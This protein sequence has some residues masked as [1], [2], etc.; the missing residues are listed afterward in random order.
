MKS[1]VLSQL[2]GND[3]VFVDGDWV[4]S[5][6]QDPDGSIRLIQLAD[7]GDGI[8]VNKSNRYLTAD[9]AKELRCTFLKTDDVL[10][11]RMPDPL[12]RACIFP[13]LETQ[14]V[15]VVDVC[16]VRPDKN[17]AFSEWVMYLINSPLFRN[18]IA[19][20]VTGT[21]RQRIS[22]GNLEKIEFEL[23]SIEQQKQI[24]NILKQS[25]EIRQKRKQVIDLLDEYL[26]SVFL[27]MFGDP[28][29]N[30]KKFNV[31][32]LSQVYVNEKDGTKCGPFGSAL[33]KEE[34]VSSGI[35]VWTM[36]NIQG[37][38][39]VSEDSLFITERKYK[40]LEKYC[41]QNGDI[42]ISRAGTVGKMAI[43]DGQELPSIISTNLIRL[44]L[45]K[46][47]LL[48]LYFVRLMN[49]CKGRVGRLRTGKDGT[50]THMNTGI[51]DNLSF[52]LPP[53]ELQNKFAQIVDEVEDL[54]QRMLK[55][56][57][58]LDIQFQA[59]MQ[60]SFSSN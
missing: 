57:E 58:E 55:Q 35:P 19:Q 51:L 17:I 24:V 49:Y 34:Y 50:F 30:P 32:K 11:A 9:K 56:S 54:K 28:I 37:M 53:I 47:K 15:T 2:I 12:G 8:F 3:G 29:D 22:R 43:V 6:D 42:I 21:T 46:S 1:V 23:P 31:I 13:E 4:E 40:A 25:D 5:K 44:R 14:C 59:L 18:K 7:I 60:K 41:V 10:I 16:I 39:F 38:D 26:K 45:D 20:Y 27:E 33:K 48:S 52:P 36:D